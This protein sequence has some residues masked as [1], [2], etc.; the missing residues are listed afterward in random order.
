MPGHAT[1]PSHVTGPSHETG[2]SRASSIPIAHSGDCCTMQ[3]YAG[4]SACVFRQES[5]V[6]S[7]GDR[8]T[9]CRMQQHGKW[10]YDEKEFPAT[11]DLNRLF[12]Y[13]LLCVAQVYADVRE[14]EAAAAK[15]HHEAASNLLALHAKDDT[16]VSNAR[17][18]TR[19]SQ[20]W[21]RSL[22]PRPCSLT[23]RPVL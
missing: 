12:D 2:I 6:Y 9:P 21:N 4:E 19:L 1:G 3:A 7:H 20:E 8:N 23:H 14:L 5:G 17:V 15:K 13:K 18:F 16:H 11:R 22:Y 10:V